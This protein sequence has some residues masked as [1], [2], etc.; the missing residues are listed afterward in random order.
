MPSMK[1]P[2]AAVVVTEK[3]VKAKKPYVDPMMAGV[4]DGLTKAEGLPEM[5]REMLVKSIP[6]SLMVLADERHEH[7]EVVVKMIDQ[8]FTGIQDRL[9]RAV[10]AEAA[11]TTEADKTKEGHEAAVA[12]A[13]AA[14]EARA[15][16]LTAKKSARDEASKAVVEGKAKVKEALAAQ[17][18]GDVHLKQAEGEKA[19]IE[20]VVADHVN[21]FKAGGGGK[22]S[23]AIM[24]IAKQFKLDESL[25]IAL[26]AV[27]DKAPGDS[28]FDKMVV[29]QLDSSLDGLMKSLSETLSTGAAASAE[30]A[31]AVESAAKSLSDLGERQSQAV[32]E[33]GAAEE[34]HSEATKALAAAE[35]A[36]AEFLKEYATAVKDR[37]EKKF[38]LDNFKDYNVACFTDLRNRTGKKEEPPVTEEA[39]PAAEGAEAAPSNRGP[40]PTAADPALPPGASSPPP[41]GIRFPGAFV[42]GACIVSCAWWRRGRGISGVGPTR[43][44]SAGVSRALPSPVVRQWLFLEATRVYGIFAAHAQALLVGS[45]WPGHV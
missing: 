43:C 19:K 4:L 32:A 36:S 18:S 31:A 3:V 13:T 11:K 7:Q 34:A 12:S 2:A 29:D 15:G 38:D 45:Q 5:C 39:P 33:V 22:H 41:M 16:E 20:Q 21:V 6:H 10:D 8:V 35:A 40:P 37:E 30:R 17:K 14:L 23:A 25:I 1:R 42:G 27:F 26:P 44:L 9:Q 24:A 28:V